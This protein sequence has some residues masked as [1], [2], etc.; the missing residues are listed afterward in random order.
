MAKLPVTSASQNTDNEIDS[1]PTGLAH[2]RLAKQAHKMVG[3]KIGGDAISTAA[4]PTNQE[5]EDGT[6]GGNTEDDLR[7]RTQ[8]NTDNW[9][10]RY[11][12]LQ[13]YLDTKVNAVKGQLSDK[14]KEIERLAE[15]N[16]KLR[17]QA[18]IP[19]DISTPEELAAFKK[20][21]PA[22]AKVIET[23]AY[24]RSNDVTTAVAEVE[25]K[26]KKEIA[27]I[28]RENA[29]TYLKSIHP[30]AEQ[31]SED[32]AFQNWYSKQTNG[33][34]QLFNSASVADIAEGLTLY[35]ERTKQ[36]QGP[37]DKAKQQG[38][39]TMDAGKLPGKPTSPF[40][41]EN[42]EEKPV[43]KESD[44]AKLSEREFA[45]YETEIMLAQREGRVLVGQ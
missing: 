19:T 30:D 25:E 8:G 24:K 9:Q 7:N 10:K 43:F 38:Q 34:K 26:Y 39:Y 14:D 5:P 32:P 27:D 33:I 42:A 40:P 12:D 15:E 1:I 28:R 29:V 3:F 41:K 16:K 44:I 35:K 4:T 18:T 21:N 17:T 37:K 45:K 6:P 2:L 31:I 20:S 36:A 13:S 22:F 11:S 23:I